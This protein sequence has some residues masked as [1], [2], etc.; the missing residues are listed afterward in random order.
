MNHFILFKTYLTLH[1]CPRVRHQ[2]CRYPSFF[3]YELV[4]QEKVYQD[5]L[6]VIIPPCIGVFYPN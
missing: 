6:N 5:L 4:F 2:I 1:F 3:L